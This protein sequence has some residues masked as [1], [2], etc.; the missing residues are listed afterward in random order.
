MRLIDAD[1]MI[2]H[3]KKDPLFPMVEQ[4]GLSGVVEA[5]P[6]VDAVPVVRCKDCVNWQTDWTPSAKDS[7]Y[8]AMVDL[9]TEETFYCSYGER[10]D[11][12]N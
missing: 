10:K 7:H 2:K 11:E 6:T 8:C 12:T 1:A 5:M 3:M 9:S 4:Y